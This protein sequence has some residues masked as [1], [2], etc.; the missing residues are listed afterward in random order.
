MKK[1]LLTVLFLILL[2][3]GGVGYFLARSFNADNFQKS[4]VK[5]VSELTGR[6]FNVMGATY[7]SWVPS[8]EII[9][10]DVSLSSSKGSTRGVMVTI[11]KIA[12]QLTWKSLLNK[13][14][15]ID[16]IKLENPVLYLERMD[17]HNVNWNF[18]FR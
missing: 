1:F 3:L 11:P 9:F 14:I 5:V 16:K 8:P 2:V 15:V 6:E 4:V 17:A 13:P 10:N 18:G 12:I 7:V